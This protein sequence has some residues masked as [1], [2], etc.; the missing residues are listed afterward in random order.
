VTEGAA[1]DGWCVVC[2][3]PL[4][5]FVATTPVDPPRCA[6]CEEIRRFEDDLFLL[7]AEDGTLDGTIEY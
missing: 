3:A 5:A 7:D 4:P 6:E 1:P 2:G